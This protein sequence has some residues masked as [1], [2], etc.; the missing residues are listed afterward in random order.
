MENKCLQRESEVNLS[1]N[2]QQNGYNKNEDKET[3]K[4]AVYK[5]KILLH[6]K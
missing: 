6:L 3:L 4:K 2:K 1:K 5:K